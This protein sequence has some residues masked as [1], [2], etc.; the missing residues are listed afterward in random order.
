MKIDSRRE[1]FLGTWILS[2][3]KF[4]KYLDS[5]ILSFL[6]FFHSWSSLV[7]GFLKFFYSSLDFLAL[8]FFILD[9]FYTWLLLYSLHFTSWLLQLFT[10][11]LL[12]SR[13]TSLLDLTSS[14]LDFFYSW[15]DLTSSILGLTWLLLF[16]TSLHS[17]L[18]TWLHSSLDLFTPLHFILHSTSIFSYFFHF[19]PFFI[20][21]HFHTHS[22]SILTFNTFNSSSYLSHFANLF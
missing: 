8:D 12:H 6:K 2:Y 5:W 18:Q 16:F 20:Y 10:S 15:L 7:L 1:L 17:W 19:N 22:S 13:F 9:F 3:L 14:T 21:T 4:L 11:W